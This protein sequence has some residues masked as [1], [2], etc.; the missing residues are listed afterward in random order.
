MFL[1]ASLCTDLPKYSVTRSI[2]LHVHMNILETYYQPSISNVFLLITNPG[3]IVV[4]ASF[5]SK[6]L[7]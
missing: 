3:G 4:G 2:R 5:I 6:A 7:I 1:D